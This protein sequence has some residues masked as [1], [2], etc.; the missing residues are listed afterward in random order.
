MDRWAVNAIILSHVN[1][2]FAAASLAV[3][4]EALDPGT[5]VSLLGNLTWAASAFTAKDREEEATMAFAGALAGSLGPTLLASQ[6]EASATLRA[7]E[8]E[9]LLRHDELVEIAWNSLGA[10]GLRSSNSCAAVNAHVWELL[11]P[12]LRYQQSV[13]ELARQIASLG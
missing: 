8:R 7:C 13:G 9:F 6:S 1:R 4:T 12:Q 5:L 11:F 3:N 10:A 2:V